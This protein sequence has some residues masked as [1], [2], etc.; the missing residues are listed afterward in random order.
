MADY[1]QALNPGDTL[2]VTVPTATPD[3]PPSGS[4]AGPTGEDGAPA[5]GGMANGTDGAI[6]PS[7]PTDPGPDGS[8]VTQ[9]PDTIGGV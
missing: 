9:A 7:A 6:D 8:A 4:S 5:D 2:T 3:V 1:A